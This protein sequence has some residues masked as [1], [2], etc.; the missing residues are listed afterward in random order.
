V[1]TAKWLGGR[2]VRCRTRLG[3]EPYLLPGCGR[4]QSG[5]GASRVAR[6][7][8]APVGGW[9]LM[10]SAVLR[11]VARHPVVA[12]MVIGLGAAFLAGVIPPIADAQILPFDLPLHGVVGGV[13]G[14][15]VGAFFVT[16][17]LSGSAGVADLARRSVRWRSRCAGT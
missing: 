12:F 10:T 15:G 6:S 14:V 5:S 8:I 4:A 16:H 11:V 2:A 13:L 9:R 3:D 1:A 17:A 7:L